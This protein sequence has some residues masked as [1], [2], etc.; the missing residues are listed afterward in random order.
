MGRRYQNWPKAELHLHLEGTIEP[1]T[2]RELA[3]ELS[4]E[5]IRAHYEFDNFLGFLRCFE[6]IT[7]HLRQPQDYALAARRLLERLERD[8]VR[9]AEITHSAGI[10][11][12]RGQDPE[13]VFAAVRDAARGSSVQVRWILDAVRQFG[14]EHVAQVAE[15]AAVHAGNG[16][17]AFGIGGDEARGKARDFAE[18]YR[19]ARSRGLRLTAHA[20]ETEGPDSVW[21]A[22]EIGAERIGH[23]I[24]AIE[25]PVLVRHLAD[26]Q[27]PLEICLT[28]NLATGAVPSLEQHPVRR[29]FEAG[30]PITLNTD[31]PA[32]FR[33]TLSKEYELAATA[34]GF[35]QSELRDIAH[36]GFR[37][38]FAD[39][40]RSIELD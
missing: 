22:L 13:A 12:W 32:L 38:A 1:E 24:R 14:V 23:G 7:R 29:L 26:R 37:Y 2:L 16:V 3:P 19:M 15:F 30:V 10:V 9:Y 18:V 21:A 27:I 8:N 34:L 17:V 39:E 40:A 33:T 20:G 11:L 36:N 5:E 4:P 28:S 6:R 35:S 31:D 25:D